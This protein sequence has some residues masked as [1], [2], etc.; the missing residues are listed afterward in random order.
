M[1]PVL[2]QFLLSTVILLSGAA[3]TSEIRD[4]LT[5]DSSSSSS[6]N[7][8]TRRE[9][10][11]TLKNQLSLAKSTKAGEIATAAENKIS[12]L[13]IYVFGSATAD[14]IYTL[15]ERFAYR[16]TG[17][18]PP[19]ATAITL[20]QSGDNNKEATVS[21]KVKKGLFVRLYAVANQPDLV[22]PS[23]TIGRGA[24]V[25]SSGK[26]MLDGDFTLLTLANPGQAGTA[27]Q[28]LGIP[29]ETQ[30]R[31]FHSTLLNAVTTTD[32]LE[33]PLSMSGAY[34]IPLDLTDFE[35]FSRVQTAFKLTR[36]AARFD[37][38]NNAAVS[39]FT[40]TGI[41]MG[42]ARSGVTLFPIKPSGTAPADLITLPVRTFTGLPN[43]NAGITASA[44]YTYPSPEADNGY[45]I[46]SGT[47]RMN[48]TEPEKAV[49]YR[50]PFKQETDGTGAQIEVN[51][52]HRYTITITKAD[53]YHIDFDLTVA[54]WSD[55]GNELDGFNPELSV[56][57]FT[58][59]GAAE[60]AD[61]KIRVGIDGGTFTLVVSHT[62]KPV[63]IETTPT[64]ETTYGGDS[65][66]TVAAPI[67]RAAGSAT[68][69]VTVASNTSLDT[70]QKPHE[71]HIG[72]ITVKWGEQPE[73][74]TILEVYRGASFVTYLDTRTTQAV[75]FAAVKMKDDRYWA[76][77]NVGATNATNKA[78]ASGDITA[79]CGKLFQ[80]G[81]YSGVNATKPRP[82]DI[83]DGPD[84]PVGVEGRALPNMSTWDNKFI[85]PKSSDPNTQ[86]NWLQFGADQDNPISSAMEKN[87]W[88]QQLWNANEGVDGAEVVKVVANDPCP[89][90]WRVPTQ[91][92]WIAIGAGLEPSVSGTVWDGT[93][94]RLTV[95]GKESGKNLLLP[96]TGNRR[97]FDGAIDAFGSIGTYWSSSV[98]SDEVY[99]SRV[100]F[101][102]AD[103]LEDSTNERA[104]GY[105]IRCIQE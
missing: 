64:Y 32:V 6:G 30:F 20:T 77:I 83:Y 79:A 15:Q 5:D 52:N 75:R 70:E 68:A 41:S 93:N 1:K 103:K 104:Y 60:R 33:S 7:D 10:V 50:I 19:T 25:G 26:I 35:S 11:V 91:A 88:Y 42:N 12:S 81:R 27:V 14:G 23:G 48:E 63:T 102:G 65:W 18:T 95:P 80:W 24:A 22:D 17:N 78:A 40:I 54:D 62:S 3:C 71:V 55:A 84:R 16:E 4:G 87:A 61:D 57:T 100:Y 97:Y 49:A 43:A 82:N 53:D 28:I 98:P 21:L 99:A 72:Y 85:K 58:A 59:V 47:Y 90:G 74:Q 96:A 37:V 34:T 56:L 101:G 2:K 67:S 31:T 105:S 89:E 94:I 13:D 29:T 51:P 66:L 38:V 76:P 46:L 36:T 9:V 45:I 8:P 69:T 86:G 44:F 92:E 39:R 73:E